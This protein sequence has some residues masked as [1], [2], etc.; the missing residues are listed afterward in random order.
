[1]FAAINFPPLGEIL[2]WKVIAFGGTPFAFNKVSLILL[3]ATAITLALFFIAGRRA[4]LVPVGVQN[5]VEYVVDF[6]TG[7][8]VHDIMGPEGMPWVPFLTALFFFIFLAN[9]FEVVPFI[10]M[11]ATARL[12]VTAPLAIIIYVLY[13]SAGIRKQG[14]RAYLKSLIVPSGVP[15]PVLIILVPIEI[16]SNLIVRPFALA[17]RLFGNMLAG[18]LLLT[19][20]AVLSAALLTKS[21]LVVALP[22][23]FVVLV[24]ITGFEIFVAFL[25]AYIFTTLTAVY[26]GEA[27]AGG[28]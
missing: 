2:N 13:L 8:I 6:I 7:S 26:V 22:I 12:G 27:L 24:L 23:P 18:H 16:L 4:S 5:A 17:I 14:A 1:M 15:G 9:V 21:I 28:H 20:F 11:P 3:L 19:T 10:Q 25:Q